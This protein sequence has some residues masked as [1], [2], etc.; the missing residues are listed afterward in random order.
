LGSPRRL[1]PELFPSPRLTDLFRST[2]P[3][4]SFTTPSSFSL[5]FAS[6]ERLRFISSLVAFRRE[7]HLPGFSALFATS[8]VRS[9][10][11]ATTP[12]PS[13]RSVL[14]LSQPFDV[15]LRTRACRLISSRCHV[16]GPSR[17]GGSLPAQPPFLFGRSCP[18]AVDTAARSPTFAGCRTRRTSAL[19]PSSARDRVRYSTVIHHAA[20]RSPPRVRLL[21]AR[22]SLGR[23]H[24]TCD[25]RSRRFSRRAFASAIALRARPQRLSREKPGVASPL[26][27]PARAF[28]PSSKSPCS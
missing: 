12:T 8:P 22:T 14:R 13:L 2:V 20:R 3:S 15:F 21:Q 7:L 16:Q 28:E 5:A 23:S 9:H 24:L 6:S 18:R 11:T 4:K 17:S 26:H 27:P 19:R 10:L 1:V 25:L